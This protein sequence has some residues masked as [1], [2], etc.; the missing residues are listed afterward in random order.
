M[1]ESRERRDDLG[2]L[3]P[4]LERERALPR[5]GKALLGIE[6]RRDARCEAQPLESRRCENDRVVVP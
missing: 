3:G 2:P 5:G 1:G 4:A 6:Q